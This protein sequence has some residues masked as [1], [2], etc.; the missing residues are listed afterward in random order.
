MVEKWLVQRL[1]WTNV[2]FCTSCHLP[3]P[4]LH[5]SVGYSR[6][7]PRTQWSRRLGQA[8]ESRAQL[9]RCRWSKQHQISCSTSHRQ[10]QVSLTYHTV[11]ELDSF[12]SIHT[13][14]K[15]YSL[16]NHFETMEVKSYLKKYLI[17]TVWQTIRK[18][19][20]YTNFLQF[21]LK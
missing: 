17:P 10:R 21:V 15:L 13:P 3:R 18:W 7:L 20:S 4:Q 11:H 1:F 8:G 19:N 14:E 16:C 6:Q 2:F 9:P 12:E 5:C